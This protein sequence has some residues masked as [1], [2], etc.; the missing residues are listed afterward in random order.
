MSLVRETVEC[1]SWSRYHECDVLCEYHILND[2]IEIW[3]GRTIPPGIYEQ[4]TDTP[5]NT[6]QHTATHCNTLQHTAA[7]CNTLQHTATHCNTLQHTAVHCSALQR[8][9][10]DTLQY[11]ATH[12]NTLQHTAIRCDT[13][14][15][16]AIHSNTL[17]YTWDAQP[18]TV[19]TSYVTWV[20]SAMLHMH[21]CMQGGRVAQ[22]ALARGYTFL[23]GRK[24]EIERKRGCDRETKS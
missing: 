13:L 4:C 11:A 24:D 2:G 19:R 9:A 5:C 21:I 20:H 18:C 1:Q 22:R 14:Q 7:H 8:T 17:Q 15:Y 23:C 16:T 10:I 12:C 6:Q 3:W